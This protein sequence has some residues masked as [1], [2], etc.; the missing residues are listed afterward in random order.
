VVLFVALTV[1]PRGMA[2]T[3]VTAHP[4]FPHETS[5][6]LNVVD[7]GVSTSITIQGAR[8]GDSSLY[9]ISSSTG[10]TSFAPCAQ[11]DADSASCPH[12]GPLVGVGLQAGDDLLRLSGVSRSEVSG[13]DGADTLVGGSGRDEMAGGWR[14]DRIR[15]LGGDDVIGAVGFE[16]GSDQ[17][18]GGAGDDLVIGGKGRDLMRSGAGDDRIIAAD[19]QRDREIDC[20]PGED[21]AFIDEG[22]DPKPKG[23]E[24]VHAG[25]PPQ[26]RR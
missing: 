13:G 25:K 2:A 18:F 9:V 1:V 3:T 23:C 22:L 14:S 20:G 12:F 24:H 21:H 7:D 26:R 4:I 11:V 17:L 6:N 8:E 15:S 16:D 5:N 10:L 19:N